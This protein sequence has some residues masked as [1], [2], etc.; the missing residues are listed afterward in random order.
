MEAG[1]AT[2]WD[3]EVCWVKRS[4]GSP[5]TEPRSSTRLTKTQSFAAH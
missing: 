5:E 2:G 1:K 3:R 4:A